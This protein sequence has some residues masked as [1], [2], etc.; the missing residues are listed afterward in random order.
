MTTRSSPATRC[1][2][3]SPCGDTGDPVRFYESNGGAGP[4]GTPTVS[5]GRVYAMGATGV[6]NALDAGNGAVRGRAMR[7]PTP[8]ST[9][10]GWGI[11]S[12]PLVI[13]DVVIVAISGRL[14][15][16][17][18]AHWCIRAGSVRRAAVATVRRI[19]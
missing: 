14:V 9:V 4:R 1:R 11:A 19:S 17:D 18:I 16:Y 8:A 2:R 7:R 3:A 12:S 15:A 13:D 6:L 5:N 10:P